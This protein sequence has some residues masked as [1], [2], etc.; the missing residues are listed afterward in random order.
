MPRPHIEFIQAQI[1]PW[2][3]GRF[4][5]GF[6]GLAVKM[7]SRD[8]DTGACSTVLKFPAG[9]SLGAENR[10]AASFEFLVLEGAFSLNGHDYGADTYGYWR[11]GHKR[12]GFTSERGAVALGF[13]GSEPTVTDENGSSR[14]KDIPFLDLHDMEWVRADIDP[15]V[16]FL[17][18]SHKTLRHDEETGDTTLFLQMGAHTHP[19][20]WKERQLYHPCVEEMYLLTGDIVSDVGVMEAGAYFWRPPNLMHGPFG[21]RKGG[22]AVIR[23]HDGHHVNLWG[24]KELEFSLNPPYQPYLPD[25]LKSLAAKPWSPAPNY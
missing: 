18:L 19:K 15:D 16:Q 12:K 11:A 3:D 10:S 7:L 13:F 1:L 14:D 21:A 20:G 25:D 8:P 23:F 17:N 5:E 2:E 24:D 22:L 4:A 9:W 6:P